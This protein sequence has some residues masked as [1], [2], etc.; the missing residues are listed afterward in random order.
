M[1]CK[2]ADFRLLPWLLQLPFMKLGSLGDVDITGLPD[3][4]A[5]HVSSFRLELFTFF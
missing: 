5:S 4:S 3:S 2:L 1:V